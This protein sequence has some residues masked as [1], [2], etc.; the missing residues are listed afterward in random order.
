MAF[1]HQRRIRFQDADPAGIVFFAHVLTFCHE[2]YE[3]LL[4]AGGLPIERLIAAGRVVYPLRHA[5][6]DFT[7]PMRIG[8]LVRIRL[9][10]GKISERSFRVDY[11]LHDEAGEPLATASTVHVAVERAAMRPTAI[12]PE[13]RALLEPH[14]SA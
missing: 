14:L 10:L 7:A 3:E 5:E 9:T 12:E 8:M 2:A 13:L 4:R 6:V 1:E 11:A